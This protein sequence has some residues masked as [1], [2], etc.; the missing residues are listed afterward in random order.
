[1][2]THDSHAPKPALYAMLAGMDGKRHS[3]RSLDCRSPVLP[4]RLFVQPRIDGDHTGTT[5]VAQT[6]T[7]WERRSLRELT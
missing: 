6:D 4:Q 5:A 3:D 2:E 7:V 1:M